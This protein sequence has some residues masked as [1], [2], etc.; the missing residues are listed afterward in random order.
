MI[1]PLPQVDEAFAWDEGEGDRTREWWLDAH[2]RYFA[3]QAM[4]EGLDIMTRSSQCS[5]A[6]RSYGR[7]M[8]QILGLSN[9]RLLR[10]HDNAPLT[11]PVIHSFRLYLNR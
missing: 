10:R 9:S 1:K 2:R 11:N 7:L 6:S 4:R 5:G 8:S 3:R